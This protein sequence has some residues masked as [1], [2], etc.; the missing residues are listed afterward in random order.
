[1]LG[2]GGGWQDQFGGLLPGAKLLE[3]EP[4]LRQRVSCR[5]LPSEFFAD[6]LRADRLLLYYTGVTRVAHNVLGEIVRGMFLNDPVRLDL[7]AAIGANGRA[8]FE[9]VQRGEIDAF[10]RCVQ[11]SWELNQALDVGTNPPEVAAIVE[12]AAPYASGLK[13]AGAGGGGFLFVVTHDQQASRRLRRELETAP[14]NPR[15]RF[16]QV[17]VSTS[18]LEVTRS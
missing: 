17:S 18:G 4:G 15:A 5:W 12:R 16:V 7:L 2:S 13:L 11:R 9:A 8:C 3:T 6:L 14:P 10:A 1:M